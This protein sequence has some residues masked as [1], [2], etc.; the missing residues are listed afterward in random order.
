[1]FTMLNSLDA[2]GGAESSS[3]MT[4][5]TFLISGIIGLFLGFILQKMLHIGAAIIG[6]IGGFF[7][8]VAIYN[9]LFFFAKSSLLLTTLSV[10]GSVVMAFLSLRHYDNIVIFGTSFVGAYSFTRGVSLF[11][12]NF[13]NEYLLIQQIATGQMETVKTEFYLYLFTFVVLFVTGS[14]YQRRLREREASNNYIKL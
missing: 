9:L 1:M 5:L 8:G 3:I 14:I 2:Q 12:G 4:F 6:A 13:P 10:L 7:I 11:I